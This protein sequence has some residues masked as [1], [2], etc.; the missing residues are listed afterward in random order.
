MSSLRN[1]EEKEDL[2]ESVIALGSYQI[3]SN[4]GL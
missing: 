3:I 2:S 1:K 4:F